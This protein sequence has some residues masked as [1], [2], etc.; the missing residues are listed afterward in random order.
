MKT[1]TYHHQLLTTAQALYQSV[2]RRQLKHILFR[3]VISMSYYALFHGLSSCACEELF[4]R[5]KNAA[6]ARLLAARSFE[7]TA[8]KE[9]CLQYR[10]PYNGMSERFK[11]FA[12]DPNPTELRRIAE[13]FEELQGL[14]HQAD[15]DLTA[16]ISRFDAAEALSNTEQALN[17][18]D[19]AL[20]HHYRATHAF[21]AALLMH[22]QSRLA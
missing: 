11:K 22:R 4:G 21:L 8:M 13:I 6:S 12:I 20:E 5:T 17:D 7:H 10:K 18:L 14:R 16:I 15:Y 1:N 2:G 19:F 3:R 9:C